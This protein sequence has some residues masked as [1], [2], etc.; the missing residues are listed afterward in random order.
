MIK[1]LLVIIPAYNEAE[2]ILG[3]IDELRRDVPYCDILVIND[4]STDNTLGIIKNSGVKYL[5]T[6]F[7]LRYAGV[8]QTG[9]KYASKKGY[10]YVAQFD[11]DGQHVALELDLM[12]K[13]AIETNADIVLGSRFKEKTEYKHPFFRRVGTKLF[14]DIIKYSCKQEI[15]DPTSG[16]QVLKRNV[17]ERYSKIFNYPEYPDANL[18]IEMLLDGYV[19][20]EVPVKMRERIFGVSMHSGV[21]HPIKYMIRMF[22][23]IFIILSKGS[24]K[25]VSGGE[26]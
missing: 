17:Y 14:Q 24:K 7:N 22:Y 5:T 11:G 6:P 15:T 26:K 9:F 2:N 23:N 3:V 13:K 8:I 18:I 1:D 21:W 20:E 19:I 25:K 16:L 10:K 4:C 12:Y